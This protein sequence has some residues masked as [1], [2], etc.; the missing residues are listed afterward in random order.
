M[1]KKIS[2]VDELDR[3]TRRSE[4]TPKSDILEKIEVKGKE[5]TKETRN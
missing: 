4:K 2:P 3:H 1:L 5:T